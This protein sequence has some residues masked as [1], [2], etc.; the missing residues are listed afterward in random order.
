MLIAKEIT[1]GIISLKKNLFMYSPRLIK[2]ENSDNAP[3]LCGLSG[4]RQEKKAQR[5]PSTAPFGRELRAERLGAR[6]Q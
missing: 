6:R 5:H 2:I 4:D 1:T 3:I